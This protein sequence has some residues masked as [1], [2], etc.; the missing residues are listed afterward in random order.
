VRIAAL[1]IPTEVQV[2]VRLAPVLA[3]TALVLALAACS[4]AAPTVAP[5]ASPSTRVEVRLTDA[6]RIEPSPLL[7][8]AGVPVTF[9]VTNAGVLDHELF[10]GDEGA[11]EQHQQEVAQAGGIAHDGPN[12]IALKPGETREFTYTF[13]AGDVLLAGCHLPGHYPAGMKAEVVVR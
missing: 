13:E 4:S 3:L 1:A 5:D 2:K 9:V 7:V 11:Q 8:P 6:L 12:G 10:F